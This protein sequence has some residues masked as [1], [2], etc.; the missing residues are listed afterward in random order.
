LFSIELKLGQQQIL[1]ARD[2]QITGTS[3]F[4]KINSTA[5]IL[6]IRSA[7]AA[8]ISIFYGIKDNTFRDNLETIALG[9]RC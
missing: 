5:K 2:N 8:V 6:L 7:N 1:T 4:D 3:A 9:F